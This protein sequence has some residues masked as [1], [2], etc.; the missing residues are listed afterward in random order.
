MSV[1]CV[2]LKIED[3][4]YI[5]NP[6]ESDI[7]NAIS[8]LDK[9]KKRS[10]SVRSRNQT[11]ANDSEISGIAEEIPQSPIITEYDNQVILLTE[12]DSERESHIYKPDEVLT[13]A[14]TSSDDSPSESISVFQTDVIKQQLDTLRIKYGGIKETVISDIPERGDPGSLERKHYIDTCFQIWSTRSN[15]VN[16]ADRLSTVLKIAHMSDLYLLYLEIEEEVK[17]CSDINTSR[18]RDFR[19]IAHDKFCAALPDANRKNS[20]KLKMDA[21]KCFAYLMTTGA[22]NIYDTNSISYDYVIKLPVSRINTL[23]SAIC[24]SGLFPTFGDYRTF[25]TIPKKIKSTPR[26]LIDS[27]VPTNK[28][29]VQRLLEDNERHLRSREIEGSKLILNP[30]KRIRI[31]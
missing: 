28:D 6:M 14:H 31:K 18:G 1:G 23:H 10:R 30:S 13:T 20:K 21:K 3:E 19:S 27:V 25:V 16:V 5:L 2:S 15:F 9:R 26:A 11:I 4:T 29:D 8:N 7:E 22:Q 17:S 12:V 24:A